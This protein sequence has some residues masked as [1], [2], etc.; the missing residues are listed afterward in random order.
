MARIARRRSAAL[1]TGLAALGGVA[2]A[3][4]FA[5]AVTGL[6]GHQ[7]Q[8]PRPTGIPADVSTSLAA[9][10]QLSPVPPAL[11]PGFTLTD[12]YGRRVSLA[13]LRGR[14]VVLTFMDPHCTDICPIVSREYITAH[15]ELGAR[16]ARVAFVAVN[17]NPYH[18]QVAD[19]A[20]WSREQQLDS[21][22][23][24]Y[25]LTG[26]VRELRA[27]WREYQIAVVA[28]GPNADVMHTSLVFFIDRS[29]HE[30][31]VAAPMVDH[32]RSGTAY[33]PPAQFAE[34]ARGI[35]L[36]AGHVSS[37]RDSR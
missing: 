28:R 3:T 21:I 5:V 26:T 34:W 9:L 2:F 20:A 24:W 31:Y 12:Q 37:L 13:S 33:L 29:G 10:M 23:S 17:V 11:A 35:A 27:V 1:L 22:G 30:R 14:A 4:A 19:V 32:T 18:Y 7:G 8:L 16:A 6:R 15:R 25:F 36:M